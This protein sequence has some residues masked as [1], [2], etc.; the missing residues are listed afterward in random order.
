MV[1]NI[2][3]KRRTKTVVDITF[4]ILVYIIYM[5]YRTGWLV[6]HMKNLV[7]FSFLNIFLL[8]EEMI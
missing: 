1:I 4:V 5:V 6:V 7:Q 8:K 2:V 3:E